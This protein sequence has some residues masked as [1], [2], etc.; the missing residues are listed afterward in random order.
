M[1]DKTDFRDDNLS[2]PE[3]NEK[4]AEILC[5]SWR[6]HKTVKIVRTPHPDHP[7]DKKTGWRIFYKE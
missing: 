2:F 4:L 3:A 1:A 5:A 7:Q 6:E